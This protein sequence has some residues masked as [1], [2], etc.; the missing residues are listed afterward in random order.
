MRQITKKQFFL[1]TV[2]FLM[3][4][5]ATFA[6]RIKDLAAIRG[7]RNNQL[8]G[9]SIVIGL[10]GTG[11]TRDSFLARKPLKNAL[12]RMGISVTL[13]EIR[14]RS[15]AAVMVTAV[16]PP[17]AKQG[18][19]LDVTVSSLG[20]AISLRGGV[21]IMTPLRAPNRE[22]YAVAQ[23]KI[24]GIP[25]GVELPEGRGII[26]SSEYQFDPKRNITPTVGKVIRGAIV[27]RE[28]NIDLNSR[29]RIFLNLK[30]PDF[31]TAFRVAKIINKELGDGSARSVDAGTVELSVPASFLGQTVE[32]ISRVENMEIE[33]DAIA[34]V[35]LDERTGTIVMGTNVRI[36][37]IA[38]SY[39]NLNIQ[40]GS[41]PAQV[42]PEA[43]Q[44]NNNQ[45][46]N[47]NNVSNPI[48][49]SSKVILFKGGVDI[50]EVVDGLN[51]IGI[52]NSDLMEVLKT[53]KSAGALQAELIIN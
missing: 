50:K 25:L 5:Q 21:L 34:K 13:D 16:L 2:L 53:I 10:N 32:L 18:Q 24:I 19:Q 20:N 22:V 40:I 46:N 6:V 14:G 9:F 28:V 26:G 36:L 15:I 11:D 52:S 41:G 23:G 29:T 33:P 49:V 3:S 51:K 44:A 47:Q 12:E 39:G 37:P 27:E 42:A 30:E 1:T 35:V 17:F 8:I 31:T 7:M 38:I 4:I 43:N 48:E 45:A